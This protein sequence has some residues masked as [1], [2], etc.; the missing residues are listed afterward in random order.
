MGVLIQI[1]ILITKF[2]RSLFICSS[3]DFSAFLCH[4]DSSLSAVSHTGIQ[5]TILGSSHIPTSLGQHGEYAY[6]FTLYLINR[7]M[8]SSFTW[9]TDVKRHTFLSLKVASY[10]RTAGPTNSF[11]STGESLLY[12]RPI[13]ERLSQSDLS[14]S[15]ARAKIWPQLCTAPCKV[16]RLRSII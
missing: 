11:E 16:H 15:M 12:L 13:L 6:S 7:R 4:P 8:R 9:Q 1:Y 2:V 3:T 14:P 10:C 5:M